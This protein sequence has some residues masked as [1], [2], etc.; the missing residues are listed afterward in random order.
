ML[1]F[2]FFMKKA[3]FK[4]QTIHW[5]LIWLTTFLLSFAQIVT[6][7]WART[8]EERDSIPRMQLFQNQSYAELLNMIDQARIENDKVHSIKMSCKQDLPPAPPIPAGGGLFGTAARLSTYQVYQKHAPCLTLNEAKFIGDY[9]WGDYRTI[10]RELRSGSP[11]EAVKLFTEN[12][13]SVLSKLNTHTRIV[14]R[15]AG[16]AHYYTHLQPG[17]P[18]A[19]LAFMSTSLNPLTPKMFSNPGA[20]TNMV[21]FVKSCPSISVR[22]MDD[23]AEFLCPPETKFKVLHREIRA[24]GNLYLVLEEL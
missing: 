15:G 12:L 3:S 4:T 5:R 11:S 9:K 21:L 1:L 13:R 18:F 20:N 22:D 17:D 19:D 6:P 7:A 24:N 16:P 14:F 8:L 23:E 10:N 2:S